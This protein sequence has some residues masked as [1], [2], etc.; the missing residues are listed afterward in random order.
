MSKIQAFPKRTEHLGSSRV[1]RVMF[2][3]DCLLEV[4]YGAL[5]CYQ[6]GSQVEGHAILRRRRF[7]A[8][9]TDR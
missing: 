2:C 9:E 4:P 3:R 6:C 5:I 7:R 1:R 8:S